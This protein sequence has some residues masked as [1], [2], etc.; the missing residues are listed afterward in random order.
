V[1][2]LKGEIRMLIG[3]AHV[4]TRTPTNGNGRSEDKRTQIEKWGFR[5]HESFDKSG[6]KAAVPNRSQ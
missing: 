4:P 1:Q 5:N 6:R 2:M 3:V